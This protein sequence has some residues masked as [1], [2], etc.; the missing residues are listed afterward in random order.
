MRL[1]IPPTEVGGSFS[2]A[3]T[4]GA[5]HFLNTPNGSWGILQVQPLTRTRA[6]W[7]FAFSN[8]RWITL[9]CK[10]LVLVV[11]VTSIIRLDLNVPPTAV[12]G[13]RDSRNLL[14]VGGTE[15]SP[16]CP[17]GVFKHPKC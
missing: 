4:I 7:I 17:L 14:S 5:W 3:Y 11:W 9:A 6:S 15:K 13:I 12:G 1:E 2:P 16:N 8:G 10:T